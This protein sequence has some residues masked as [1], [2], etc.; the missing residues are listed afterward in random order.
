M[1]HL[2]YTVSSDLKDTLN[3]IDLLRQQVL[4][5]P[6]APKIELKLTWEAKFHRVYGSLALADNPLSKSLMLKLL[7]GETRAESQV[8][9]DVMTYK[10]A[11][12]SITSIWPGSPKP[13]TFSV[14]ET[15]CETIA[16]RQ[17]DMVR[18][19]LREHE[20][21]IKQLLE[22]L[23]DQSEH[24]IIQ[25]AIAN[26]QLC[27]HPPF[28]EDKGRVARL[29]SYV[30]LSKSGY[31]VR[32]LL[33]LEKHWIQSPGVYH[34]TVEAVRTH[35]NLT[36]WLEYFATTAISSFEETL[37]DIAASRLHLELPADFWEL[38]DRQKALMG[39]LD[40]PGNTMTNK[41]AQKLTG[42][43][44]ITASRDLAKLTKLG[45]VFPRGKGRSIYY[46]RV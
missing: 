36:P 25:S 37:R 11:L 46:T 4:V 22:Y 18:R 5:T 3:R 9:S 35:E 33:S 14:I 29:L 1:L 43:S 8:T 15:I 34:L 17:I 10:K 16:G 28:A 39:H 13:I 27:V 31:G 24:P 20:A 6:L 30:F 19:G 21:D 44:Q 26:V 2:A 40:N 38:N 42:V 7:T 45:L 32:G 41:K 12:D 23:Q